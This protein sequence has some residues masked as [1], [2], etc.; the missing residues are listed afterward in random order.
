MGNEEM[1]RKITAQSTK[2]MGSA[3]LAPTL[4]VRAGLV[5]VQ[6]CESEQTLP[7]GDVATA[8]AYR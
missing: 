4:N 7:A 1:V 2:P 3:T 5:D 6:W 8:A